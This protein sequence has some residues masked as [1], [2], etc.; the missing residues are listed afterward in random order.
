MIQVSDTRVVSPDPRQALNA[1]RTLRGTIARLGL[2]DGVR[3]AAGGALEQIE[4]EI[5]MPDPDRGVVTARLERFTEIL[6][7]A[8][9]DMTRRSLIRS[10]RQI[11]AWLG[12]IGVP[13][14][15]RLA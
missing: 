7:A 12:P 14:V 3:S 1:V 10:I 8:G 11:A 9:V 4:E 5:R 2:P 6:I 15:V 13:L